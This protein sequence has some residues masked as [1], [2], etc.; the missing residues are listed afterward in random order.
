MPFENSSYGPVFAEL[1]KGERNRALD[2]GSPNE[3]TRPALASLT[4][5]DAFDHASIVD[6]DQARCCIAAVWLLHDFLDESHS[7]SQGIATAEGSFWHAIMHR[8]EGDFSNAKYWFR[9]VGEHSVYGEISADWTPFDFVDE[10]QAALRAGSEAQQ[11]CR[12]LQQ[13]EWEALFDF[14]YSKATGS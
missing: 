7:V 11:H 12:E 1:L 8:R 5:A 6:Q 4:T 2:E 14:C 3:S 9:K 10:C 13:R